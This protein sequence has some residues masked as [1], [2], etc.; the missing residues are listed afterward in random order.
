MSEGGC[1][2]IPCERGRTHLSE[3]LVIV[4]PVDEE[5]RPVAPGERAAKIY[6]T[7][8]FNRVL[9]LVR[10]E[11]T[12]EVT[13][14][15]EPCPCGS[16]HRCVADIQGRLDDVFVY[17]GQRV[18]PHV[19]RSALGRRAGVVEY[20]VH[21]T[22]RGARIAVRCGA[23]VDLDGLRGEIA[24]SLACLGLD[25][26]LV[27]ITAVERLERDAGPAKLRRFVPLKGAPGAVGDTARHEAEPV[28]SATR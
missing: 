7:N 2:G 9:P 22:P 14:L 6:L 1:A 4:E 8:L 28:L 11:I 15:T 26:P 19:F 5:G 16:A 12:D 25:R 27:E 3:D 17:D 23:P 24:L 10:Y 18:H 20:Q 13:I 21:Q